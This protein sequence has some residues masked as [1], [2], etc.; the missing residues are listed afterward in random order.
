MIRIQGISAKIQVGKWRFNDSY[1][2]RY[3][4][5]ARHGEERNFIDEI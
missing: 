1:R 2:A 5:S 3:C 4:G